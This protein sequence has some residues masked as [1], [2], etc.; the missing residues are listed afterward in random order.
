MPYRG[1]SLWHKCV[2]AV[3]ILLLLSHHERRSPYAHTVE[4][5]DTGG[6][7]ISS[8]ELDRSPDENYTDHSSTSTTSQATNALGDE[9]NTTERSQNSQHEEASKSRA[10][11]FDVN[12][13]ESL[14]DVV[15]NSDL[16]TDESSCQM[17]PIKISV[18]VPPHLGVYGHLWITGLRN[19]SYISTTIDLG[20]LSTEGGQD[21]ASESVLR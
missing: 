8:E 10:P 7:D 5:D 14:R 6:G 4:E 11:P 21:V 12:L 16:S 1:F 13:S 2:S 20:I 3:I 19:I 17:D 15:L 9:A 18:L